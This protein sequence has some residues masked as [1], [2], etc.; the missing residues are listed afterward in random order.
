MLRYLLILKGQNY[1]YWHIVATADTGCLYHSGRERYI[2]MLEHVW[3]G[4]N[5]IYQHRP[6]PGSRRRNPVEE[7]RQQHSQSSYSKVFVWINL[8][9]RG[10]RPSGRAD[11]SETGGP[12]F[13]SGFAQNRT[14]PSIWASLLILASPSIVGRFAHSVQI[15]PSKPLGR[16]VPSVLALISKS[17]D[18][19]ISSQKRGSID[20]TLFAC[21][22][23]YTLLRSTQQANR[24]SRGYAVPQAVDICFIHS[25]LQRMTESATRIR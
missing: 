2:I 25:H 21:N 18:Q 12:G 10:Q 8:Y 24:W 9:Q 4:S 13:E 22:L 14:S 11:I 7:Q 15:S 16:F 5:S 1:Y 20:E 19:I 23:P 17:P 6:R 3:H